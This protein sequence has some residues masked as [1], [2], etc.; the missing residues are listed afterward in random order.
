MSSEGCECAGEKHFSDSSLMT[1]LSFI[2]QTLILDLPIR[3]MGKVQTEID[4][5]LRYILMSECHKTFT[6]QPDLQDKTEP[7]V[8]GAKE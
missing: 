7:S 1:C 6:A 2:N 3:L 8:I 5:L 4:A